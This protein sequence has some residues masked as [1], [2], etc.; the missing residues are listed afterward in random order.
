M[1]NAADEAEVKDAKIKEK[2]TRSQELQDLRYLGT[3]PEFRRF[4]GKHLMICDRISA[5]PSGSMTYFK[6]GERNICL[7]IKADI[8]DADPNHYILIM[9]EAKERR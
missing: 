5:D 9:K 1:K 2:V 6:E 7:K 3:L 4:I 8:V